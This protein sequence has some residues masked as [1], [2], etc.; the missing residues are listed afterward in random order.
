MRSLESALLQYYWYSYK[1]RL[2]TTGSLAK[3]AEKENPELTSHRHNEI[4]TI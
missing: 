1:R 3:M 2:E 4:T